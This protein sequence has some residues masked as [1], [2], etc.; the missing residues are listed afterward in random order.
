MTQ[1]NLG[2]NAA[3]ANVTVDDT[4]FGE[5]ANS[6]M[7]QYIDKPF[8]DDKGRKANITHSKIRNILEMVNKIYNNVLFIPGSDLTKNQLSDIA[9]LKV[10][11]AY[12]SGRDK[13]VEDFIKRSCIMNPITHIV[14]GKKKDDFL[15]Y[16][17]YV[18][19]LVAYFKYYGGRD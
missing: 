15:L 14:N 4:N 6:R 12:E 9:Y 16:C 18:E 11:M 7:K 3:G 1:L 10:K 2:K 17:R 5:M 19:S 8:I 13:S